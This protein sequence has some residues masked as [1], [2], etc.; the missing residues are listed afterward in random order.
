VYDVYPT[1]AVAF[2]LAVQKEEEGGSFMYRGIRFAVPPLRGNTQNEAVELIRHDCCIELAR[3]PSSSADVWFILGIYGGGSVGG[4]LHADVACFERA[5]RIDRGLAIAWGSMGNVGG[6]TVSGKFHNMAA[7]NERVLALDDCHVIAWYNLGAAGGGTVARHRY[8]SVAC[9]KRALE[10]DPE[11]ADAWGNLGLVGGGTVDSKHYNPPACFAKALSFDRHH[12]NSWVCLGL[13]GGGTVGGNPYNTVKCFERALGIDPRHV[14]SLIAMGQNSRDVLEKADCYQRALAVDPRHIAVWAHF[15][16]AGGCTIDGVALSGATCVAVM[17]QLARE[18]D[19]TA[20]VPYLKLVNRD[21]NHP[22][23][24]SLGASLDR[25]LLAGMEA[26][27]NWDRGLETDPRRLDTAEGRRRKGAALFTDE[28]FAQAQTLF[29]LAL[30]VL[31]LVGTT[32]AGVA[33]DASVAATMETKDR[34]ALRCHV[35]MSSCCVKL[36]KPEEAIEHSTAALDISPENAKAL[37][38]RGQAQNQLK[39]F[40]QAVAD[41]KRAL[42]LTNGDAGVQAEL[43]FAESSIAASEK[44][45]F[46]KMFS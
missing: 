25:R 45:A 22:G 43:T 20:L 12:I 1:S 19:L 44:K 7:C 15:G 27:A 31:G 39:E 26:G 17:E 36:G 24:A 14:R 28:C 3:S 42:A 8:D 37:F 4:E 18:Q 9:F 33:D 13:V 46:S 41:L 11:N 2:A 5:L 35:N 29:V 16:G 23:L 30:A 6:G 38:R 34:I 32:H 10:L 21:P 40:D